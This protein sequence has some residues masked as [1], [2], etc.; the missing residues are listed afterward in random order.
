MDLENKSETD[1]AFTQIQLPSKFIF[2]QFKTI[3]IR[4]LR[5]PELKKLH[6]ATVIS[7]FKTL[8]EAVGQ[9]ID[10]PVFDLT[11]GDFWFILYWLR[12]NSYSRAPYIVNYQCSNPEHINLTQ[13]DVV[14][15]DNSFTKLKEAPTL[16]PKTLSN[17]VIINQNSLEEITLDEPTIEPFLLDFHK[18]TNLYL[19][20]MIVGDH[21]IVRKLIQDDKLDPDLDYMYKYATSISPKHHGSLAERAALLE[22]SDISPDDLYDIE[23]FQAMVNHGVNEKFVVT[24]KECKAVKT[25]T[26]S[27]DALAFFPVVH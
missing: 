13:D 24:C 16:D 20:P 2:Y 21:A 7:D 26:Q 18:R 12:L 11:L 22:A 15:K 1:N 5:L 25:V 8:A 4:R 14:L 17:S 10:R 19:F 23:V 3:S 6:R 9:T 27:I